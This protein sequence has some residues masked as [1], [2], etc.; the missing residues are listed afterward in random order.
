MTTPSTLPNGMNALL[1][2]FKLLA[3]PGL[4]RYAMIPLLINIIIFGTGFYFMFSWL[5]TLRTE[6]EA[7]L[8]QWLDFLSYILWPLFI[9]SAG[10]IV[11]YLFTTITQIL[12]S[13]FNAILSE[14]VEAQ[15]GLPTATQ[16]SNLSFWQALKSA[17]AR[18]ISK[19]FK[20]LKWLFLMIVLSFIPGLN[21]L[22]PIIA[23]WLMAIDYLDYPADNRGMSF[24]E[25]LARIHEGRFNHLTFGLLVSFVSLIPIVNLFIVPAAVAGGTALWHKNMLE[26][27]SHI[28]AR[29][30]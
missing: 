19:F 3:N 29:Q 30:D 1:F 24:N 17:P 23:G 8:P 5:E 15:L 25:S 13:P 14:K 27:K 21:I 18:E 11:V 7:W 10:V 22:V 26:N 6:F 2:G 16:E 20:S 12:S 9:I 4:K 28:I